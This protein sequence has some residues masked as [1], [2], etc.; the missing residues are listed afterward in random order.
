MTESTVIFIE[1]SETGA[2]RATA[3]AAARRGYTAVLFSRDP[4]GYGRKVL[5]AF[6]VIVRVDTHDVQAI[7]SRLALTRA[8]S[9]VAAVLTT[10][11][12]YVRQ[13]ANACAWL[14][15]PGLSPDAA[16]VC[17]DKHALRVFLATVAPEL[18]P[19]WACLDLDAGSA[20]ALETA[21]S[22]GW[23]ILAKPADA[24]DSLLVRQLTDG[25]GLAAWK[26]E[27]A[28]MCL[29]VTGQPFCRKGL[30]EEVVEGP[31]YSAEVA[32]DANGNI[33]VVAVFDKVL[34]GWTH[35]PF[36]KLGSAFP[37]DSRATA[38]V[39]PAVE[40]LAAAL[41][42]FVGVLDVDLR[43]TSKGR[44]I[45]LEVNGR[46]AGDQLSSHLVR[47]ATDWS[48][49]D[50]AVGLA[51]GEPLTRPP[52]AHRA[53]AVHRVFVAR[54][55]VF[56]GVGNVNEL[57]SMAGVIEVLELKSRGLP[58]RRALSNQDVVASVL[59]SGAT[60][61]EANARARDAANAAQ[62]VSDLPLPAWTVNDAN[63]AF[64]GS[65]PQQLEHAH[66]RL[67]ACL[68]PR[69][70]ELAT[71]D[72]RSPST[73]LEGIVLT[74]AFLASA[75]RRALRLPPIASP[76]EVGTWWQRHVSRES[77]T[78]HPL[79]DFLAHRA[80]PKQFAS[81]LAQD[82]GVHVPFDDVL[83]SLVVGSRGEI[84][85]EL[86]QNLADEIEGQSPHLELAR[87]LADHVGVIL[88]AGIA[89]SAPALACSNALLVLSR[90]RSL[91]PEAI[92]Y[93]ACLEATTPARFAALAAGG[94]RLGF[95]KPL[96]TY[97]LEHVEADV[98]HADRWLKQVVTPW[99]ENHPNHGARIS[100]GVALRQVLSSTFWDACLATIHLPALPADIDGQD[101][102]G[103]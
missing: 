60:A 16:L 18:N 11:D 99:L 37:A 47:L 58:I 87:R 78:L 24:N 84:R 93:L 42:P 89:A 66:R 31:E 86:L 51:L 5:D 22:L 85:K 69:F 90:Y 33:E 36:V 20:E 88:G 21:K 7:R 61:S 45:V 26:A 54:D 43:I 49:P 67:A 13:T 52:A 91:F 30:L 53:V 50:L 96:L 35:A 73:V 57:R 71:T 12:F 29:D 59:A 14:S 79:F 103:F 76:S 32:R 4:A 62:I 95:S 15:L 92:G 70:S 8:A 9:S 34:A 55:G 41:P 3:L 97:Y 101:P 82:L 56:Q 72:E 77:M 63:A 83:S 40:R 27:L 98:E 28:A 25:A 100:E 102:E 38:S 10:N 65:D 75:R 46:M 81:F 1:A 80:E 94:A 39:L 2:G 74:E 19:R 44:P 6:S 23:P 17:H 68:S 64:A 48:L